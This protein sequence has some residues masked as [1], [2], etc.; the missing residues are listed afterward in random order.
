MRF[1]ALGA[2]DLRGERG[3]ELRAVLVQ[4]KRLAL[5]AY[6]ALA[7]PPR[8][9]RRDSLFALFWPESDTDQARRSLRQSL[10]FLRAS[11]GPHVLVSRGDEEVG[12]NFDALECDV[13]EF[14]RALDRG[15]AEEALALYR[16]NLL[17]G[18]H[19]TGVAPEFEQWLDDERARLRARA[20]Q[21]AQS[22]RDAARRAGNI[23]LAVKYARDSL[24]LEPSSEA[25]LRQLMALLDQAGDRPAALRAYEDFSKRLAAELDVGP[26][27]ETTTLAERL[28]TGTR[29]ATAS[30]FAP[31][32]SPR[33][34]G[35]LPNRRRGRRW[36]TAPL[37]A[38]MVVVAIGAIMLSRRSLTTR[39]EREGILA[40]G[41]VED[42]TGS[43]SIGSVRILRDLLTTE[44]ARVPGVRVVSQGRMQQLLSQLRAPDEGRAT[45]TD[46]ARRA[47]ANEILEGTLYR[48]DTNALRL[49]LRRVQASSG[50]IR[51]AY[52]VEGHDLFELVAQVS[53]QMAS[54]VGQSPPSPRLADLTTTSLIARRFYEEGVRAHYQ[55]DNRG[56]LRF[57]RAAL[58]EDSTFAMAAYFA[59]RTARA[60]GD[61]AMIFY[62]AQAARHSHR[63]TQRER[64]LI[65]TAWAEMTN[66][67][68]L[69]PLAESL[70][71]Q[72]PLEPDAQVAL[73]RARGWS[74]DLMRQ[75]APFQ[76]AT[77]LDAL[78][79]VAGQQD[80]VLAHPQCPAC[81]GLEGL[82]LAY[83]SV[84][85]LAR[86]ER[87]A[88][89]WTRQH[90]RSYTAWT[91]LSAVFDA[92]GRE[93]E[94][95]DAYNHARSQLNEPPDDT[96]LRARMAIRAGNFTAADRM[97]AERA[98]SDLQSVRWQ[99]L[100]WQVISYRNQ[101]RLR[102]ALQSA[103]RLL[104]ENTSATELMAQA[105]V[106]FEAG[107]ARDAA[108]SF[109]TAAAKGQPSPI[110]GAPDPALGRAARA[111][112]WSLTHTAVAYDALADTLRV[113]RLADSVQTLA[114]M[115]AFGR[116][117]LLPDHLRGLLWLRRGQQV[118]AVVSF[119]SALGSP[120]LGYTRTNLELGRA[121]TSLGQAREAVAIIRPALHGDLQAS[122]Y[123]VTQAEL[124]E[125]LA[126]AFESAG[127]NDS[128][129]VHY[130]WV[131]NAWRR[132]DA[133]LQRRA[134][135]ARAKAQAY[136][137]RGLDAHHAA[138][139]NSRRTPAPRSTGAAPNG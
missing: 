16:G 44:L 19:V 87:V 47:G 42:R 18:F 60:L 102:D 1:H 86:A 45:L 11:L 39:Q 112:A 8:L 79:H 54:E 104:R 32:E 92:Q 23:D 98:R 58:A 88:R 65:A 107:K 131:A 99:A 75:I 126:M 56:A 116:D 138:R 21:A 134:A 64:L 130:A 122:N 70:A 28:K 4:P 30:A 53:R 96:W 15:R 109:E 36:L 94:A 84:D 43:D 81:D 7:N 62:A 5:F 73:G 89:D 51:R 115:G 117:R 95:E 113:A 63:A 71:A 120:T 114:R 17:E 2:I 59:A 124:H 106:L 31:S 69:V 74:G 41:A 83:W 137:S 93:R 78:S 121:L 108:R 52:A 101:G 85:S 66:S 132:A 40:V 12:V 50:V 111:L 9:H 55:S 22:L 34:D 139:T 82:L 91:M 77:E 67:P 119:R 27:P 38:A 90:P 118:R 33:P 10:H 48:R 25:S 49:D 24:R 136:G 57:F 100:W 103:R 80:S 133:S 20:E 3:D 68:A 128:A 6:L 37:A 127:S 123:Y 105:Q 129:A 29:A 97:L 72:F 76:R 35:D 13:R 61:T 110:E 26:S 135:Q 46:V 14:E 125:A